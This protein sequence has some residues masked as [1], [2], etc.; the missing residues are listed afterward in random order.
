[1]MCLD[2]RTDVH[3]NPGDLP[4]RMLT[5]A[6][7]ALLLSCP[8]LVRA[9]SYTLDEAHMSFYFKISHLG[10]SDTMGRF[11]KASG[12]FTVDGDNSS[13]DISIDPASIDTGV[14]K[15]DDHL[16]SP[17]FFNVRQFPRLTFKSTAV[18][19]SDDVFNITGD[20]TMHGVT[21]SITIEL[22]KIGEGDGP[23]GK[24]RVG[25]GGTHMLRRSDFGMDKMLPAIGDEVTL[26]I[27]FE[28]IAQ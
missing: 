2:R 27:S 20:L 1:M 4:M 18:N 15:R 14:E 11:N 8:A 17:D 19:V 26:L 5:L 10:F 12:T 24:K 21:R 13:F 28:G 16:R 7:T 23:G 25:F 6:L 22:K 3:P 9:E